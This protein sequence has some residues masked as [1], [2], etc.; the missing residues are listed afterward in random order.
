[1][2]KKR[3]TVGPVKN[4]RGSPIVVRT[5]SVRHFHDHV[6]A[7]HAHDWHQLIYASEGVMWVHT[8]QGDWVVPPNR[9]VWVPAGVEHGIELTAKVLVQT[10]YLAVGISDELPRD[11]CAVNVSPLLRE[12]IVHSVKLGNLDVT[13][14]S[15][16]RLIGFLIDQLSVLPAIALQLPLPADERASAQSHGCG[17]TPRTRAPSDP[18]PG[19]PARAPGRSSVCFCKK[20]V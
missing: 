1:M 9:A 16:A 13:V 11:C 14:P 6:I 4:D 20:P 5:F 15:R 18:W 8:A 19:R 10:V 2:S 17:R 7:S 12:L 3:Q